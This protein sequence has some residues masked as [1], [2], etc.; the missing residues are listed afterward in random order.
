MKKGRGGKE[1]GEEVIENYS[2]SLR[3]KPLL[4]FTQ[5]MAT[6]ETNEA[7]ISSITS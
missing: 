3:M 1:M 6:K 2:Q 5:D 4:W 7:C